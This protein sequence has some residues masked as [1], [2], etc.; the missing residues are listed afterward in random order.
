MADIDQEKIYFP[1]EISDEPFPNQE[2]QIIAQNQGVSGEVIRPKPLR[3]NPI[4]RKIIAHETIGSA[5]NTK[6]R[7]IL[8]E[9][10]FTESGALQIGKYENGVSGD[11]RITPS[12]IVARDSAGNITFALDGE[13]G[14][15]VFKGEIQSGSLVTGEIVMGPDGRLVIGDES[16]AT[17]LDAIGLVSQNNFTSAVD[18][19][20]GDISF[21]STTYAD[22]TGLQLDL[23]VKRPTVYLF[24]ITIQ[25]ANEQTNAAN[26]MSGRVMINLKLHSS[27]VTYAEPTLV[28]DTSFDVSDQSRENVIRKTYT[29]AVIKML[30][31]EDSIDYQLQNYPVTMPI[32]VSYKLNTSPTNLTSHIYD[33]HLIG[34]ALGS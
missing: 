3:D 16:G 17:I 18:T 6:S 8:A 29:L 14:N 24:L 21:T 10:Q 15:A 31:K 11:I 4:P 34:I 30:D 26:D 19:F 32:R 23:V 13:T 2:Q 5:L 9:F 25:V 12:G 22:I 33:C 7:K 1:E 27:D 20:A 28:I